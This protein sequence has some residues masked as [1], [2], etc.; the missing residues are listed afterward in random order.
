MYFFF[1]RCCHVFFFIMFGDWIWQS[2]TKS[3]TRLFF[4]WARSSDWESA[5]L[6]RQ[7]P[8]VQIPVGPFFLFLSWMK[9]IFLFVVWGGYFFVCAAPYVYCSGVKGI[10]KMMM[11]V[12]MILCISNPTGIN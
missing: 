4:C 7:R 6:A 12:L 5:A 9:M 1:T 8:R 11:I 10:V 2:D 3:S